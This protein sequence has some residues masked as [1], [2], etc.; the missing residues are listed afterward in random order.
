M[1]VSRIVS[2]LKQHIPWQAKIVAKIILTRLPLDYGFWE[3]V[4]LFKH[5]AME[6][7]E[8]AYGVFRRH[9][10]QV[11][12]PR[13]TGGFVALEL[14]PGDS[15]YSA[16]IAKG[17]GASKVYLVYTAGFAR[18]DPNSYRNMASYLCGR[19]HHVEEFKNCES[20]EDFLR[21]S[22]AE[23]LTR[24]VASLQAVP[25]ASVDFIWSQA[26]LEHIRR[27]E[28]LATL[29]ELRRIQRQNGAGSH[30]VDLRDH[31]G[32]VLD[33]LRFR[34]RVWESDFMSSSG[35]Y[36]NRIRY[37]E[38]LK[39]FREAGFEAEVTNVERWPDVPTA[40]H[41]MAAPFRN[42]PKEELTV[43]G[44]DVLLH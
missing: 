32:G 25:P 28:F 10:G 20:T 8:Y 15:L 4:S 22:S 21:G 38:M 39:L 2:N 12:F 27:H 41:K 18:T 30:R 5:G 44:F 13:K 6:D 7:P 9:F 19:G 1:N 37:T 14:G 16:L 23:Y 17:F 31:L 34:E 40:A 42:L 29:R 36:T 11:Q 33:N 35:F 3:R 43:S 24:G 26:V